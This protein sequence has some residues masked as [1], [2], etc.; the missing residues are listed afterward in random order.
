MRASAHIASQHAELLAEVG[1]KI[2]E[3]PPNLLPMLGIGL[4]SAG[5]GAL[6]AHLLTRRADEER[7][8][9]TRNRSFGAGVAAGVA[10]PHVVRGLY[11]IAQGAGFLPGGA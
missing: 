9:Q 4:G 3:L 1:E 2:A 11:N 7:R 8:L 10:G 5:A 6:G